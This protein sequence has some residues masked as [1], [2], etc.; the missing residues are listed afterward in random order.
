MWVRFRA[1]IESVFYFVI[2]F[3][4]PNITIYIIIDYCTIYNQDVYPKS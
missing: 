4:N 1:F 2:F 3:S